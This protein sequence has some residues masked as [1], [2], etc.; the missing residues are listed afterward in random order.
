MLKAYCLESD[1][2]WSE[3]VHPLLLVASEVVQES[4]GFSLAD[5]ALPVLFVDH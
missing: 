5:L 4:L 2:D 1:R 3:G